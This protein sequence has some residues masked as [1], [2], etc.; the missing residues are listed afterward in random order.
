[1]RRPSS[2]CG[3]NVRVTP[4]PLPKLLS[5]LQEHHASHARHVLRAHLLHVT[6]PYLQQPPALHVQLRVMQA[7]RNAYPLRVLPHAHRSP[8]PRAVAFSSSRVCLP[9][10]VLQLVS[11]HRLARGKAQ[12]PVL[13]PTAHQHA[14]HDSQPLVL[15]VPRGCRLVPQEMRWPSPQVCQC[16]LLCPLGCRRHGCLGCRLRSPCAASVACWV[17]AQ[18]GRLQQHL[19]CHRALAPENLS[20]ALRRVCRHGQLLPVHAH[21]AP[22]LFWFSSHVSFL[23]LAWQALLRGRRLAWHRLQV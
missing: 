6:N 15:G 9:A 20:H 18:H 10:R 4:L 23:A 14:H 17:L 13:V 21:Q 3:Q 19:L 8:M 1:V 11:S 5:R 16:V 2:R 22:Q 12:A 7:W